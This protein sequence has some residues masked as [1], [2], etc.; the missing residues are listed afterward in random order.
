MI[1][2]EI[3]CRHCGRPLWSFREGDEQPDAATIRIDPCP[4]HNDRP[5]QTFV[6]WA[7][8]KMSRGVALTTVV[9]HVVDVAELRREIAAARRRRR[10]QITRI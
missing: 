5:R 7:K 6:E 8:S 3:R 1:L 10:T 2:V 4:E 9:A